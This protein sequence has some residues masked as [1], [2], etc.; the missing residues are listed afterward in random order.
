MFLQLRLSMVVMGVGFHVTRSAR[1]ASVT[2]VFALN[3]E[4][5]SGRTARSKPCPSW[6]RLSIPG[7][8]GLRRSSVSE[9]IADWILAR[10]SE[11]RRVAVIG[12]GI[13]GVAPTGLLDGRE[14]TTHWR[15]ASDVAR[16]FP[17]LRVDSRR[18]LVK[19]GAFIHVFRRQCS[20]RSFACS[21]R[22]RLWP[23]C[24]ISGCPG[25]CQRADER[26]WPT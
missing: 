4:S 17:N 5:R 16:C 10:A 23:P 11:T 7:G 15:Y 12:G 2:S 19:D 6:T 3:Q 8:H 9:T 26:Q 21:D 24:S 18:H 1:L 14:V 20:H 22:T 25:V 13:Y